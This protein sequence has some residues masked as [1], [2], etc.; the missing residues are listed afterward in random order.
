SCFLPSVVHVATAS[1][2]H[3][4]VSMVRAL[5]K[6]EDLKPVSRDKLD[7]AVVA[8]L[9]RFDDVLAANPKD[10]SALIARATVFEKSNLPANALADYKQAAVEWSDAV[11]IKGKI[12]ELEE[13]VAIAA[14][15]GPAASTAGGKTYAI[16]VGIS[17]YQKLPQEMWLQYAHADAVTF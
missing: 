7:P 4:G 6:A 1:Q 16:L 17:K 8:A 9:K 5:N 13:A 12:F 2:Q 11:W 3:Y 15:A 14:A 10:A